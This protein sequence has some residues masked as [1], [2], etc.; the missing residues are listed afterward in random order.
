[1]VC[2][3]VRALLLALLVTSP[4]LAAAAEFQGSGRVGLEAGVDTN[5]AREFGRSTLPDALAT[6]RAGGEGLVRFDRFQLSGAYD[7]GARKFFRVV[8]QDT[9]VQAASADF[10]AALAKT[11]GL[12]LEG[13][14]KDRR[15]GARSYSDL[16]GGP[17]LEY[18]P[19][20]RLN[21]RVRLMAHRFLYPEAFDYSFGAA[22]LGVTARYRFNRRHSLLVFADGGQR[23]YAGIA[24]L[25]P[26]LEADA[27][28]T[29]PGRSDSVFYVGASYSYRGPFALSGSYSFSDQTSNSFGEAQ[30]RHRLGASFGYRLPWKVIALA[31][32]SVQLARYPDGVF[33]SPEIILVEDEE[34][35]N[36]LTLK[37]SRPLSRR[38]DVE[39]RYGLY[40][41]TLSRNALNYLRQLGSVG[42][43]ARF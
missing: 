29:L 25:H 20:A 10:A 23:D 14:I 3:V 18:A 38:F 21:L 1:M 22:E 17:F 12:G 2:A 34:N 36:S 26:L 19:D 35:L 13:R 4:L 31:Q 15:G 43:T 9:L 32:A 37:L 40:A 28:R 6:A 24:R 27:S 41:I 16:V 5:P 42:V 39:V 30:Q 7:L 33:L 8:S 11:F